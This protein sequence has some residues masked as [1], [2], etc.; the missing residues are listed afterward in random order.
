MRWEYTF[1]MSAE[2]LQE[3]GRN[4][5]GVV[6]ERFL[7]YLKT[8]WLASS[9]LSIFTG[10]TNIDEHTAIGASLLAFGA[11]CAYEC[12]RLI[13]ST[14]STPDNIIDF[15]NARLELRRKKDTQRFEE[16]RVNPPDQNQPV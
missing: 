12:G 11:F 2:D 16:R 13:K 8:G 9:S 1:T 7:P 6:G 5:N 10:V 15:D 3:M 14:Q 4:E